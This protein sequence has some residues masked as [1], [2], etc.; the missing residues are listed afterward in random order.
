M[1]RFFFVKPLP[2][3]PG[4]NVLAA[5]Y[6]MQRYGAVLVKDIVPG[7]SEIDVYYRAKEWPDLLHSLDCVIWSKRVVDSFQRAGFEGVEFWPLRLRAVE[8]KRLLRRPAPQ[9]YWASAISGVPAVPYQEDSLTPCDRYA[10]TGLFNLEVGGGLRRWRFDFSGW[11]G[12]DLF[13]IST[14]HTR[15][16]LCTRRLKEFVEASKFTNFE[17]TGPENDQG[18]EFFV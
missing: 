1:N 16:R 15:Y 2:A 10:E 8:D 17:F 3:G 4:A 9:Y 6:S 11:H 13:Y 14:A 7:P 18:D 12:A 5:R